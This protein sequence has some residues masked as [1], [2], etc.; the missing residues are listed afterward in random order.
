MFTRNLVNNIFHISEKL[1]HVWPVLKGISEKSQNVSDFSKCCRENNVLNFDLQLIFSLQIIFILFSPLFLDF[2]K[3]AISEIIFTK[4]KKLKITFS[5]VFPTLLYIKKI[6]LALL[7]YR[8]KFPY[9][10]FPE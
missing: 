9:F 8:L 4:N 3:I 1:F 10:L 5:G 6:F 7:D 2:L